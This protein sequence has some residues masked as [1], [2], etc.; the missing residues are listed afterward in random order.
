MNSTLEES[1]ARARRGDRDAFEAIYRHAAGRVY[2]LALRLEGRP[3]DAEDLT[4][5][6]FIKVWAA[7][8]SFRGDA[9]IGTWIHG[10]AVR[11]AIDRYRRHGRFATLLDAEDLPSSEGGGIS[12]T[13]DL[14]A[15]IRMLPP[16]MRR[17]TV[18]HLVEGYRLHEVAEITGVSVG[19]VKSQVFKARQKLRVALRDIT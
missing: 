4:Q 3:A 18:L 19:T 11:T 2:A 16:A 12:M 10:I 6:V 8:P 13:L 1:I 15:A 7:L 14:D 5:E 17:L 9:A